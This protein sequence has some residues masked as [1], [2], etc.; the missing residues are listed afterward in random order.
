M[1]L[2]IQ[3]SP[4]ST[5]EHQIALRLM[6]LGAALCES[7]NHPTS[8]SRLEALR[9]VAS[10]L[11]VE[12]VRVPLGTRAWLSLQLLE[13]AEE[14]DQGVAPAALPRCLEA[15][16]E[17]LPLMLP[18]PAS[19]LSQILERAEHLGLSSDGAAQ[20]M[21]IAQQ[22]IADPP[23]AEALGASGLFSVQF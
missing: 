21:A 8:R 12:L 15:I 9:R 13:C 19:C 3:A 11:I 2:T 4:K 23:S 16:A 17:A 22:L 5:I 7:I 14:L 18:D 1:S 6:E 20:L 10:D